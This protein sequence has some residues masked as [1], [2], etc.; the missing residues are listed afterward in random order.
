MPLLAYIGGIPMA[1]RKPERGARDGERRRISR[2]ELEGTVKFD[3][4]VYVL[5]A[6]QKKSKKGV[7]TPLRDVELIRK[8]LKDAETLH[9]A[10]VAKEKRS[11]KASR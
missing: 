11:G 1:G 10:A 8:P 7:K 9:K 2:L 4:A 3:T 6:F 5:Q